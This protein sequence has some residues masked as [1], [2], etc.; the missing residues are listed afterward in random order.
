[1]SHISSATEYVLHCLLYLDERNSGVREASVRDLAELQG[2]PVDY[3]AKLFTKLTKAGIVSATEGVKGG[4]TLARPADDITVLE[5]VDAVEGEKALF[6]C[7]E[8]RARCAVYGDNPPASATR[9]VCG[10]HAVMLEADQRMREVLAGHTVGALASRTSAKIPAN[11]RH[12]VVEWFGERAGQRRGG[13][14][15]KND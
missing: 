5:V 14:K 8:I 1:M 12:A 4:F 10:I 11:Y 7:R 2:V 15:A 3:L 6:D 13:R 9:G